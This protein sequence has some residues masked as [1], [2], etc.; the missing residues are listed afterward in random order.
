MDDTVRPTE[1]RNNS[2]WLKDA[3]LAY[4]EMEWK[5]VPLHNRAA[6]GGCTC[7]QGK[8]CKGVGKHPRLKAWEKSATD[9]LEQIEA[10]WEK[11]PDANVGV[12]LGPESGIIDIECDSPE[13]ERNFTLLFDGNPPVCP[14]F[15][16]RRG[17]HRLFKWRP[18]LPGGACVH[19]GTVEVRTGN[20]G[21]GA[22]TAFPPSVNALGVP[23][24]WLVPP[25]V[26]EPPELPDAV[27]AKLWNLNG[28][29]THEQKDWAAITEPKTEGNRNSDL[30]SVIGKILQSA[31]DLSDASALAVWL[32]S[33]SAMNARNLPPLPEEEVRRTFTSILKKEHSRR[34]TLESTGGLGLPKPAEFQTGQQKT[35]GQ[36]ELVIYNSDPKQYRLFHPYFV[37]APG[38]YLTLTA[39][40][41]N[42]PRQKRIKALE[43]AQYPIPGEFD[44]AWSKQGGFYERLV[45]SACEEEAPIEQKRGMV[46][47]EALQSK[48]ARHRSAQELESPDPRGTPTSMPDGSIVFRFSRVWEEVAAHVDKITRNELS[49]LLEFRC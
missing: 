29:E 28:E 2:D 3:A 38:G 12:R 39:A 49:A 48:L 1:Q 33:A 19:V 44:K 26:V 13:A 7:A 23:R 25:E 42:S 31:A 5:V 10:W 32:E 30:A 47:A 17:K 22:Q 8:A 27:V 15:Q 11:W 34:L 45:A 16:S 37:K 36:Y 6:N 18:D 20:G 40:E 4:A 41:M 43:Q 9:D 14:T 24:V 46:V 35:T 21:K